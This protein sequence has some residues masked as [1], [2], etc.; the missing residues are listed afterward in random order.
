M[1]LPV[2]ERDL[3]RAL[4]NKVEGGVKTKDVRQ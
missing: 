3:K 4:K 2:R 1:A